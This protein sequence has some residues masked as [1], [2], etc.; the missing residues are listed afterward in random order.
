MYGETTIIIMLLAA[1]CALAAAALRACLRGGGRRAE[2]ARARLAEET[3]EAAAAAARDEIGRA[4][5]A[6]GTEF[7]RA[8]EKS[9]ARH[10]AATLD[11][12]AR[13]RA[14]SGKHA[15]DSREELAASF[16]LLGDSLAR[17]ASGMSEAQRAQF[18][19]L[20]RRQDATLQRMDAQLKEIR[21]ETAKKLEDMRRT[22]D[23]NLKD[24]VEKRFNDSFRLIGDRLERVHQGLGE[25]QQLAA[26]V[27]D[28]K[29]VL[30]NVKTRGTLG[31]VRL[32][33]ILE[34]MLP[35]GQFEAQAPVRDGAAE[36]V[37]Y[38]VKLPD[39]NSA[40][41]TLL[42]PIDSKFPAE[43]YQRLADAYE[44]G[45]ADD[46]LRRESAA[47]EASVRRCARDIRDKYISPPATTDFAIMFVPT[48][49][50]YAEIVRRAE[51]F[52]ALQR[53]FKVTVVGPTNLS[54]FLSSLQ[55]GF[56]TLAI[57]RRSNEVWELLG[58]VKTEFGKYGAV[59]DRLRKKLDSASK[60]ADS[61]GARSRAIER[62]LR[63]VEELPAERGERLLADGAAEG[64]AG[65]DGVM[66]DE[67]GGT[68]GG[69]ESAGEGGA[70]DGSA[71]GTS[72]GYGGAGADASGAGDGDGDAGA[73]EIAE[74]AGIA[75]VRK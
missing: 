17:A 15:R 64:G 75:G 36:R 49:S 69:D 10:G 35:P 63:A 22:V 25:M 42:L 18:G 66:D 50:L 60:E 62:T 6:T 73:A 1:L 34:Q 29:R 41:K 56:R 40:G 65:A 71:N 67:T 57:E 13:S 5:A 46:E 48:E 37:D 14:E 54:A 19:D 53:V 3:A 26:G 33:A 30:T 12:F 72:G 23:E 8:L 7:E 16:R 2:A 27:G 28:L 21:D 9:L 55:M 38:V 39:K 45:L 59:L 32:G 52:E 47:F 58:A 74:T 31:E 70:A 51:L 68:G 43:D 24:T 11:E 44:A 61:I 20:S 4:F